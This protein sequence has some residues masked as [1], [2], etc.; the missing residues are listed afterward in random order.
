MDKP[1][2]IEVSYYRQKDILSIH[3]LPKRPAKTGGGEEDFLKRY[4]KWEF[5]NG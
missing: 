3:I 2:E 1:H 4:R 5:D